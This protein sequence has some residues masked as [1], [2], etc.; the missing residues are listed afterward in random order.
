MISTFGTNEHVL[1]IEQVAT[2][3]FWHLEPAQE[4]SV[5]EPLANF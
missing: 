1:Y 4:A 5:F 3:V 2:N